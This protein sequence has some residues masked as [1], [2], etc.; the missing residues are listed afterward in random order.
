[1]TNWKLQAA[2]DLGGLQL[3]MKMQQDVILAAIEDL[4]TWVDSESARERWEHQRQG[5]VTHV[6]QIAIAYRWCCRNPE[7]CD[8]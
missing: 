3:A 4:P 1:M 2:R 6:E 5:I 8:D 7:D